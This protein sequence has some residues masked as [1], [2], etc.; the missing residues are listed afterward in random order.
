MKRDL[1]R[2]FNVRRDQQDADVIDEALRGGAQVGGTNLWV[3]FFAILIASVGLNVN[4]TAVIIGAML[5]SPLMGPIVGIGYGAAVNDFALIRA[6]AKSLA[7]FTA[8]S[9]ATSTLYFWASP[10]SVPQSE[11]LARTS[12]TLWDVLIA[13][14]GGAAGMVAVT[15]KSFN[16]IVPGVAIATALMPPLCTVG[17][18]LA[19]ARWDMVGGAFYLFTINGVFIAA[20]TLAMAK[21][22][23]LP[24]REAIDDALRARH[25]MILGAGLAAV[26][27][28][29]VYLGYRF[30]EHE[31]FA[32]TALAVARQLQS[33]PGSSVVA[34]EI[35]AQARSLE[36]TVV[37]GRDDAAVLARARALLAAQGVTEAQVRLRRAGE[38]AIDVGRLRRE[39]RDELTQ[40]LLAQV[41][42]NERR[43]ASLETALA[44]AT[45]SMASPAPAP[46]AAAVF[47]AVQAAQLGQEIRIQHPEVTAAAVA[48][49]AQTGSSATTE[50]LL[51]ALTVPRTMKAA[52]RQRLERWLAVRMAGREVIVTERVQPQRVVAQR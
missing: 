14:F 2:L 42:V 45:A 51:V 21:L 10:L 43:V 6:A 24:A 7:I 13:A 33:D 38:A 47:D 25:R 29:S 46:P 49:G 34:H 40:S 17:F 16:N 3:L 15:R 50:A 20:A 36:L 41:Q 5:I 48:V 9:L 22:L 26:L 12:P 44:A 28:P 11:L 39:L 27:V 52:E 23:R 32:N 4:S 31:L 18:G 37:G 35:D 1:F 19:H 8:L 30:V